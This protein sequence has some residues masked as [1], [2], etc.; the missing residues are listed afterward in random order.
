VAPLALLTVTVVENG[1]AY[2]VTATT[3]GNWNLWT[4]LPAGRA[5]LA[6]A[7]GSNGLIYTIG[8]TTGATDQAT[9]LT[10]V[11][12]FNPF[13]LTYTAKANLPTARYKLA[14]AASAS[15]LIYA[16][17]G[18]DSSGVS[19]LGAAE[20]Y[21]VA[22]NSWTALPNMPTR[23]ANLA[24][25][26]GGNGKLYAIG[27][28]SISGPAVGIVEVYDPGANV[29][30]GAAAL[31]T[32]RDALVVATSKNGMI[33]AIGGLDSSGAASAAVEVYSPAADTWAPMAPMPAARSR[34]AAVTGPDGL[35]YVLGGVDS[36]SKPVSTVFVYNPQTNTWATMSSGDPSG[37]RSGHGGPPV[38]FP[39]GRPIRD[40]TMI[41]RFRHW[42][43]YWPSTECGF[44]RSTDRNGNMPLI[45]ALGHFALYGAPRAAWR[46]PVKAAGAQLVV[47]GRFFSSCL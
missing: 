40:G 2:A 37:P 34:A 19:L 23:R 8:G 28:T 27:G 35:I 15:G 20:V 26:F 9:P 42:I 1:G 13:T 21:S 10:T 14:V 7:T 25:A 46:G 16:V 41:L 4:P 3:S 39:G 38:Q 30:T 18:Y 32:P 33:Y 24:A 6:A 36:G 11:T 31:G 22:N 47:L 43:P 12:A 45:F 44:C 29:W 17:G 5:A